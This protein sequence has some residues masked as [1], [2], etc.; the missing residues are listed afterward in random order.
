[1]IENNKWQQILLDGVKGAYDKGILFR[2]ESAA[3]IN[4]VI[5]P[6]PTTTPKEDMDKDTQSRTNGRVTGQ[7]VLFGYYST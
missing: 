5:K 6:K 7:R 3:L 2:C 4:S 1:M